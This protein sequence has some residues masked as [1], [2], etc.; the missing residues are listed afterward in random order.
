MRTYS[1]ALLAAVVCTLVASPLCAQTRDSQ[2]MVSVKESG[3][4]CTINN[5]K[6]KC[7]DAAALLRDLGVAQDRHVM[8]SSEGVGEE[9]VSRAKR[10][11]DVIRAAGYR[12]VAAVG[13]L[14]EPGRKAP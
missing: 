3:G 11:A 9:A 10:V 4:E 2:D 1:V 6:V 8:V 5:R 12:N 14:T 13:F 7:E